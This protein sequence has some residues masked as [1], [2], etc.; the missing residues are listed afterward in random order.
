M[1]SGE[2]RFEA[3]ALKV[4]S[5]ACQNTILAQQREAFELQPYKL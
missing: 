4:H 1:E 3:L 2:D 5:L